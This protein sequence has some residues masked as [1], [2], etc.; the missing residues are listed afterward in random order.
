LG[1]EIWMFDDRLEIRSP[2]ELVEPVTLNRLLQRE[3]IHASRNPRIVRTL[4]DFGYMREQGEGIPRIFDAMEQDGLVPPEIRLEADAVFTLTLRNKMTYRPETLRWL[5][6]MGSSNLNDSQRRILAYAKEH[7]GAF[8]SRDFQKLIGAD[9]YTAS[10][11]IKELIRKEIVELPR[12]GG[13][14]YE[15]TATRTPEITP[16]I[17]PELTALKPLLKEKGFIKNEDIRTALR[18][19]RRQAIRVADKLMNAGL[20]RAEGVQKGRRYLTVDK[21]PNEEL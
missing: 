8:T 16:R 20:L 4:T 13:R 17:P 11:E 5:A 2:G 15:L 12:K 19:S 7:G 21:N 10:R 9:I 18:I 3:R 14:I 6:Q 1:I